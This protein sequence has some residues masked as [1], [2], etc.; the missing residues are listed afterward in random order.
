MIT[1]KEARKLQLAEQAID[2]YGHTTITENTF[3][4]I[5]QISTLHEL[6]AY[7]TT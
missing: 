1:W 2:F 6:C 3:P 5:R 4:I 7:S